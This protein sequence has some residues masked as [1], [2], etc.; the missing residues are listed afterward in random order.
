MSDHR[1]FSRGAKAPSEKH[2]EDWIV[3]NTSAF[4]QRIHDIATPI[5]DQIIGR[6]ARFPSG[7]CDLIGEREGYLALI[8]LKAGKADAKAIAQVMRYMRDMTAIWETAVVDLIEHYSGDQY[9]RMLGFVLDVRI[10]A[11]LICTGLTD[12]NLIYACEA[13]N[14]TVILYEYD[15]ENYTFTGYSPPYHLKEHQSVYEEFAKGWL[16]DAAR[17]VAA[18]A[19]RQAFDSEG[20]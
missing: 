2:L 5:C 18:D 13:A 9:K 1:Q 20:E 7:I 14:I 15:G 11:I 10:C 16:G 12:D 8:E 6:Q 3:N 4:R 19:I 17:R